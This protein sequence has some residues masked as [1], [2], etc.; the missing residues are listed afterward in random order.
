MKNAKVVTSIKKAINKVGFTLKKNSPE[1]LIVT[2]IVG[3]VVSTV[4][5]CKATTKISR[6]L[7]DAKEELDT[8]HSFSE[9]LDVRQ[10][11]KQDERKDLTIVYA[12]TGMK[13]AKLYAPALILGTLSV[14]SILASNNI[15]KKRNVAIAAAYAAVDKGFKEYRSRV[16]DRFGEE[17][18]REL[19]H[20]VKIHKVDSVIEGEDGKQKKVKEDIKVVGK[21]QLEDYEFFFDERSPYWEKNGDYIRMFLLAQQQ[22]AN[23]K[24]RARIN[25]DGRSYLFLNEV[26]EQ[27]GIEPTKAGQVTGWV[28]DEKNPIGDNFIDFGIYEAYRLDE[29]IYEKDQIKHD[30]LS[31]EKYE[32]VVL[33]DFNVDGNI[34]ELM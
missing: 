27:L 15:L 28:F 13:I 26:L 23:D 3:T 24:L 11:S 4:I 22:Y 16:V 17:V 29:V 32:R 10:Y 5:A 20:G 12:Q 21:R 14:T 19:K 6:I 33:L 9:E 8:V 1:I 34:W 18:D 31:K 2:G 30:R 7:D 25:N